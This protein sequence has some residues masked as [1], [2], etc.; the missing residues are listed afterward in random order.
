MPPKN[1]LDTASRKK[2]K[3]TNQ[4]HEETQHQ[5]QLHIYPTLKADTSAQQ[6][7]LDC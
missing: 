4:E 5:K 7:E 2:L 6:K 3:I 1:F